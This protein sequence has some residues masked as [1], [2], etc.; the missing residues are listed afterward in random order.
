[1][2]ILT[3]QLVKLERPA[4]PLPWYHRAPLGLMS[5][6]PVHVALQ[7]AKNR[8]FGDLLVSVIDPVNWPYATEVRAS[9]VDETGVLAALYEPAEPL[10]IVFAEAITIDSGSRHDARLVLEPFQ[11]APKKKAMFNEVE[12]ITNELSKT[13]QDVDSDPLYRDQSELTWMDVGRVELGWVEVEGWRDAIVAQAHESDQSEKFKFKSDMYDLN[14]AVVSADTNRRLLR[15]VFP[16]RG[17]VSVKIEHADNPGVIRTIAGAL[18]GTELNIL[19]SLLRRGAAPHSKAEVVVVVEPTDECID[20]SEVERRARVA[21]ADLSPPLRVCVKVAR[22]VEPEGAVLYPRRPHEI[23]VRPAK[24]LEAMIRA[25][26]KSYPAD[27]RLIFIS[28]RFVD[29]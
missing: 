12:R 25:V 13:F 14:M 10:N 3:S 22:A 2:Y 6:T 18:A 23:A 8:P 7:E 27:R 17:A 29:D 4:L 15:Y 11:Y 24:P 9:K 20:A 5:G 16:R 21:L 19:S 26:R 1:M 28:R